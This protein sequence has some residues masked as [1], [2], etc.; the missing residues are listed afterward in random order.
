MATALLGWLLHHAVVVQIEGASYW[1]RQHTDLIPK[2]V[3]ANAA[4]SPPPPK[5]R[6]LPAKKNETRLKPYG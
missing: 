4:I 6:G 1:L 5:R 3:L 2:Q